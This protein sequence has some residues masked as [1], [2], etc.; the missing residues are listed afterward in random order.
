MKS[1]GLMIEFLAARSTAI[2]QRSSLFDLLLH[3]V[4]MLKAHCPYRAARLQG[5]EADL[6][7]VGTEFATLLSILYVG[8]ILCQIPSYV[9]FDILPSTDS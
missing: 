7:L 6:H 4:V 3:I 5:F 1:H 2:M 9:M 8:Y